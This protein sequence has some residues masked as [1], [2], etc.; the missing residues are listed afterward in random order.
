MLAENL[1]DNHKPVEQCSTQD[2]PNIQ[3]KEVDGN[4]TDESTELNVGK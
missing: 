2:P 1:M 4:D 3:H